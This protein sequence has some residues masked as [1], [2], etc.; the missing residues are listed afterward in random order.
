MLGPALRN[1]VAAYRVARRLLARASSRLRRAE[2]KAGKL[3]LWLRVEGEGDRESVARLPHTA[4]TFS[5]LSVLDHLWNDIVRPGEVLPVKHV[6]ITLLDLIPVADIAP[7]LFGWT[8]DVEERPERLRLSL[9]I[10][11]LNQRYGCDTVSIGATPTGLPAYMGAKVAFNRIPE[12][13][14]FSG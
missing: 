5:L 13:K 6:G 1:R 11:C 12:R 2:H 10:D 8:P 7:D 9:A 4:D 3:A 14:D